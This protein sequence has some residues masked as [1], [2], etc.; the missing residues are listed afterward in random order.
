MSAVNWILKIKGFGPFDQQLNWTMEA[1]SS[2][3]A[4]YAGNGQGKTAISRLFR[5]VEND[6][7]LSQAI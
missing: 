1:R 2:K 4:I 7:Q 5:L 6:K 3:I